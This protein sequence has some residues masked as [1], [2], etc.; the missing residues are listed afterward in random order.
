MNKI[1]TDAIPF[2]EKVKKLNHAQAVSVWR[3]LQED[4][5]QCL[6]DAGITLSCHNIHYTQRLAYQFLNHEAAYVQGYWRLVI[7]SNEKYGNPGTGRNAVRIGKTA[8]RHKATRFI[9]FE[10]PGRVS[11]VKQAGRTAGKT[12]EA[13]KRVS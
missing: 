13:F 4:A 5:T 3:E 6:K 8:Y 10:L 11:E 2:L 12:A 7:N 9:W 1:V